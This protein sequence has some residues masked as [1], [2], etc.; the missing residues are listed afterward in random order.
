MGMRPGIATRLLTRQTESL[1]HHFIV[2]SS[3]LSLAVPMKAA[4]PRTLKTKALSILT[5][6]F[7]FRGFYLA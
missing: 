3:R 6:Y 2:L 5:R 1:A 7:I 4:I